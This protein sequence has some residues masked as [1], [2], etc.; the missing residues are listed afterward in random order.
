MEVFKMLR[1]E[2][3]IAFGRESGVSKVSI[4]NWTTKNE[5]GIFM[6]IPK[7]ALRIDHFDNDKTIGYQRPKQRSSVLRIAR[8]WSWVSCG[9]LIVADRDGDMFIIDGQQR[10]SAALLREDIKT[11]PCIVFQDLNIAQEAEG[12]VDVNSNR[13]AVRM[14]EKYHALLTAKNPLAL[15]LK[16][17]LDEYGIEVVVNPKKGLQTKAIGLF[18]DVIKSDESFCR[19]LAYISSQLSRAEN[20]PIKHNLLDGLIYINQH[21]GGLQDKVI[22]QRLMKTGMN[23]LLLSINKAVGFFGKGGA[24]VYADGMIQAM[25]KGCRYRIETTK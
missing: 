22:Q 25:N 18:L 8:N 13:N 10:W 16:T 5:P 3:H 17:I 15:K 23:D 9:V 14:V 2:Q 12:F 20:V 1:S 21:T 19:L 4:Y 11:L 24:K 7:T 6:E